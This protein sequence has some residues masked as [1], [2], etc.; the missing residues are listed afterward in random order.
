MAY[1]HLMSLFTV[2]CVAVLV[3]CG[4]Y[5]C[6]RQPV[7]QPSALQ[8]VVM[9]WRA[10]RMTA[11]DAV[12][13]LMMMGQYTRAFTAVD[14]LYDMPPDV[15]MRVLH[16]RLAHAQRFRDDRRKTRPKR[17]KTLTRA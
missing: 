2:L 1:D 7:R 14:P 4:L 9:L 15:F 6:R 12:T 13:A 16:R 11:D 8:D 5:A 10:G 17:A 3:G